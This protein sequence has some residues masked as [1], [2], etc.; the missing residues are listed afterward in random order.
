MVIWC[1]RK[2]GRAAWLAGLLVVS[3]LQVMVVLPVAAEEAPFTDVGAGA[4]YTE[5]VSALAGDGVFEGTECGEGLFCPDEPILRWHMAVWIVRVLDGGNPEPVDRSR[6]GDVNS[7]DWYVTHVER[8]FELE[9][10]SGCGNGTN[11]CPDRPVKRSQMAV[12]L[13]R[14]FGLPEGPDSGFSDVPLDVWYAD[15]VAALAASG[16]TAGCGDGTMFCPDAITTRG[17]MATFLHRAIN[18]DTAPGQPSKRVCDFSERSDAVRDAVFQVHAGGGIGTAFYIGHDEWLTAAHVV[19][20][21]NRVT[22]RNGDTQ[23]DAT[24]LGSDAE[25]GVAESI[26]R[27]NPAAQFRS[28]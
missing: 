20:G 19:E 16:I 17:Q 11:Y 7:E 10:T 25:C 8:M 3:S 24:V 5:P 23:I 13:T 6:F 1:A 2:W 18:R 9:V 27:R 22:L 12:F 15:Q 4:Y 26:R 21:H 14:A 28:G